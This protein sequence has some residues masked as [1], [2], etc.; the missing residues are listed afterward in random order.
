MLRQP[1][2]DPGKTSLK[3]HVG[4][5][6]AFLSAG[7]NDNKVEP[8]LLQKRLLEISH[9]AMSASDDLTAH[10]VSPYGLVHMHLEFRKH[11]DGDAKV[12]GGGAPARQLFGSDAADDTGSPPLGAGLGRVPALSLQAAAPESVDAPATAPAAVAAAMQ[13]QLQQQQHQGA[14]S[15]QQHAAQSAP[16]PAVA[17]SPLGSRQSRASASSPDLLGYAGNAYAE[18]V[19]EQQPA[20]V[21]AVAASAAA[22][23]ASLQL[24]S[25]SRRKAAG[26]SARPS[27][28]VFTIVSGIESSAET[29]VKAAVAPA[30]VP[31]P[32][33]APGPAAAP[34]LD[35]LGQLPQPVTAKPPTQGLPTQQPPETMAVAAAA[36]AAP[37]VATARVVRPT[38]CYDCGSTGPGHVDHYGDGE[39][40]CEDCWLLLDEEDDE[41]EEDEG[42]GIEGAR[43]ESGTGASKGVKAA[44]NDAARQQD[45]AAGQPAQ[46]EQSSED[47]L[48]IVH[49][50]IS[51]WLGDVPTGA[52][53]GFD[54]TRLVEFG[55][56]QRLG[57]LDADEIYK[58]YVEHKVSTA[59][60][61]HQLGSPAAAAAD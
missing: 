51:A 10:R 26:E 40:Y 1:I 54:S 47:E 13:Q 58:S 44:G 50:K 16:V 39:H 20:A 48:R 29:E 49:R 32:A 31:A 23:A 38:A 61:P 15:E 60:A 7:D 4:S 55:A 37:P 21:V 27:M 3:K 19:V 22:S 35:S 43:A 8:E 12:D 25:N 24:T 59:A 45:G 14:G 56:A 28:G 52:H 41:E 36:V 53:R 42:G 5:L 17:V 33:A 34:S 2:S 46:A 57:H 30:L 11:D 6:C 9:Q 18:Q